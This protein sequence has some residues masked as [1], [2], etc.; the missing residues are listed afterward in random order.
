MIRFVPQISLD[1][2]P[3]E[4]TFQSIDY[5]ALVRV[6]IWVSLGDIWKSI[7]QWQLYSRK[8]LNSPIPKPWGLSAQTSRRATPP[9]KTRLRQWVIY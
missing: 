5:P 9:Q 4:E 6:E 2:P 7:S 8:D 1:L 3:G